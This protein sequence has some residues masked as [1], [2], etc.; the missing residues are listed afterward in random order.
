MAIGYPDIAGFVPTLAAE[1]AAISSR[2]TATRGT[3]A[4]NPFEIFAK[5]ELLLITARVRGGFSGGPVLDNRG[6]YVGVVSRDSAHQHGDSLDS[7]IHQYDNL[8][9]GT[10]VPTDAIV[11]FIDE[12]G[13]VDGRLARSLDMSGTDFDSFAE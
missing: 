12:L 11:P 3:V 7:A 5:T 1:K 8:G 13:S 9:Y 2:L 6:N 4:S 10:V